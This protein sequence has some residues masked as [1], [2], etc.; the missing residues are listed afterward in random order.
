MN[1][2]LDD[3]VAMLMCDASKQEILSRAKELL[4][5]FIHE[6]TEERERVDDYV[7]ET[8]RLIGIEDW[9]TSV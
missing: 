7:G 5:S 8:M 1:R 4:D 2:F 6:D 9:T 3:V